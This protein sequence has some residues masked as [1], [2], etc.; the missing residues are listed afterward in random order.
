MASDALRKELQTTFAKDLYNNFSNDSDDQYFLLLGKVDSWGITSPAEAGPYGT[1]SDSFPASNIDNV[2]RGFQAWRDSIGAKR[3]SSRNIYHMIRRYN[4]TYGT[5]YDE[6]NHTD[7][8]FASTPKQFFIYTINGN[9]YKCISNNDSAQSL[10]EPTHTVSQTVTLQDGYK[11]KFVYK[12]PEDAREFITTDYIPVQYVVDDTIDATKNQWDAQQNSI[13][14]A[15]EHIDFTDVSSTFSKAQWERSTDPQDEPVVKFDSPSGATAIYL[16]DT[17]ND[18]DDYYNGYAI[19]ISANAGVGQRRIITDY[20]GGDRLVYFDVPLLEEVKSTQGGQEGS[21]YK[22][23]PNIVFDGDGASAEAIATIDSNKNISGVSLL[24]VGKDYTVA[25]PRILP[26]G[27]SG[28]TL[29]VSLI[30]GKTLAGPT[31]SPLISPAGGHA[32]NALNDFNSDKIMIRTTVKGD[33]S[34]FVVAQD[35]R[36][37]SLVKNPTI[38]GGTY[39]GWTA[40]TEI[41]RRKQMSVTVP[42]FSTVGF[43]DQ[44]F[45]S[46]IG[47]T[48]DSIIGERSQSSAKIQNWTWEGSQG[49][50]ELSNVQGNFELDN[51]ASTDVRLVFDSTAASG[52]GIND[53][54]VGREVRQHNGLAG[55]SGATAKGV[56]QDWSSPAGG[57]YELIVKVTENTFVDSGTTIEEY[58]LGNC[59]GFT[60]GTAWEGLFDTVERRMGELLKH[61]SSTQG[62]TFE[63][64]EQGGFQNLA[65]ANKLTDVQ[66][67]ETLEKSYRLTHKLVITD[68]GSALTDSSYV[69]D[70]LFYQ[71]DS[72]TDIVKTGKVVKWS[73]TS[74]ASG[75]LFLNEVRGG[76]VTGG[77]HSS[78]GGAIAN[79]EI[80]S[81]DTPDLNIGSGQ[82]LYIQNIKS[83]TKNY[84]QDEE[85]KIMLGFDTCS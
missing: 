19:Y 18:D 30:D 7:D 60:T 46:A 58:W 20:D 80:D 71:N 39:D 77:F 27:V 74:G 76:F 22:I 15:I 68:S 81:V 52:G 23:M 5:V 14:G 56:V 83:I 2:E 49:T 85:V 6:Y 12:V 53:Y 65:R 67:E 78:T 50:L 62:V 75:E 8:L 11:W 47:A 66:D 26:L 1:T 82:V 64:V 41:V 37:V 57:P 79:H 24:N 28:G 32:K 69:A 55:L 70:N 10:Y 13:N 35:F 16:A 3:I 84:E 43:N 21:R 33:D 4:W 72:I 9:V 40:G 45:L 25:I 63:F 42:Y 59:A 38:N 48:G 61:F 44:T 51:P 17:E 36:Q 73:K 31:L 29:G 54:T 34:N